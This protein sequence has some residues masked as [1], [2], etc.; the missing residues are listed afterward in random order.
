MYTV[1]DTMGFTIS[2]LVGQAIG[3]GNIAQAK[4]IM[5]LCLSTSTVA[6]LL[7]ILVVH[8]HGRLFI[9]SIMDDPSIVE[10]TFSNLK[11]YTA[12]YLV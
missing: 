7:I 8:V 5:W 10:L 2:A 11:L 1:P 4:R 6:M 12:F 3:S 9:L